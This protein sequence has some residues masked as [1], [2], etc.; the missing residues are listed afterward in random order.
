VGDGGPS[1]VAAVYYYANRL[2]IYLFMNCGWSH[3][4]RCICAEN[5][6][7]CVVFI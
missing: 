2:R 5:K 6:S 1:L 4:K 3:V 7:C